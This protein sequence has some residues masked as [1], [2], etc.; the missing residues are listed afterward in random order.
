VCYTDLQ[1]TVKTLSQRE[2]TAQGSYL[3]VYKTYTAHWY[4]SE[5]EI[6]RFQHTQL[7]MGRFVIDGPD[8]WSLDFWSMVS[9][10]HDPLKL[11]W[12]TACWNNIKRSHKVIE[13][14]YST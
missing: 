14:E 11:I 6:R 7:P 2:E 4:W 10:T 12:P 1:T 3:L 13:N 5:L 8:D 9:V